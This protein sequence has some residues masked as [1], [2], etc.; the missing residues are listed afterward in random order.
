MRLYKVYNYF[1][2]LLC[3]IVFSTLIQGKTTKPPI[4]V[5]YGLFV[6]KLS[7]DFKASTFH[8]EFYWWAIFTNDSTKTGISNDDILQFEYVNGIDVEVGSIKNEIQ[9]SRKSGDTSLIMGFHQ[10][11]FYFTPDYSMYPFDEQILDIIVENSLFPSSELIFISDT[12]SY[13]VSQQLS[14]LRGLSDDLIKSNKTGNYHIHKTD[15]AIVDGIYNTNFGDATAPNT[16]YYSRIK[17]SILINRSFLP[18]ISKLIIPLIIILIL[19]YFV[20]FLPAEKLDIA[21]GLT[22]TSLLSAIAFQTAMSTDIPEI[23][24]IIYIDKVFYTCYFLIAL[25]MAQSLI[26]YYLDFSGEEKK[27]RLASQLDYIF[28]FLFPLLFFAAV[29]LFAL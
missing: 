14:H 6:K 12:S 24:Y 25:S 22:V 3:S 5:H 11:Q 18:Y 20:F 19:V 15:I 10:G 21:A 13:I 17:A 29:I 8:S 1:F 23:G 2:V 7:V 28:R 27:V 26:T 9:Y 16:S 4:Y